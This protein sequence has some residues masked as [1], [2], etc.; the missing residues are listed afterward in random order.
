M[1]LPGW[2]VWT[3]TKGYSLLNEWG[4]LGHFGVQV[5]FCTCAERV[6]MP[7]QFLQRSG[8]V[9]LSSHSEVPWKDMGGTLFIWLGISSCHLRWKGQDPLMPTWGHL[10]SKPLTC[11]VFVVFSATPDPLQYF[12]RFWKSD[13]LVILFFPNTVPGEGGTRYRYSRN[14]DCPH[15]CQSHRLCVSTTV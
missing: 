13:K 14:R 9:F 10:K 5:S 15:I 7:E 11:Q 8:G 6:W 1:V 12:C 2:F 3:Y 4:M